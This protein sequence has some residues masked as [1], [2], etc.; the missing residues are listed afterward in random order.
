MAKFLILLLLLLIIIVALVI[1]KC[2]PTTQIDG[3]NDIVN[4]SRKIPAGRLG[5]T[6]YEG[7]QIK[8]IRRSGDLTLLARLLRVLKIKKLP[9]GQ[10]DKEI[11][12]KVAKIRGLK[13][14]K[15]KPMWSLGTKRDQFHAHKLLKTIQSAMPL[16][17]NP[18][19]LD[20]GGADCGV[21]KKLGEIINASTI[22]CFDVYGESGKKNGVIRTVAKPGQP[23][24][25]DSDSF[26]IITAMMSLHHVRDIH[27]LVDE[28]V[29]VLKP[30]G[31]LIIRE[32][33]C[34]DAADAMI[35]NLEHKIYQIAFEEGNYKNDVF[36]YRNVPSWKRLF[37]KLRLIDTMYYFTQN[38]PNIT[39]SRSFVAMFVKKS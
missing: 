18:K 13:P 30:G 29:R 20:V 6:D 32:H 3:G 15:D 28:I 26:D 34:W 25:Y 5:Y 37:G 11:L 39:A 35:V 17:K 36:Q 22:H 27:Q 23:L 19:Y 4:D 12:Q 14:D 31:Y 38:K 33:D 1:I 9:H 24:P 10:N 21:S 8:A 2:S 16:P 7:D